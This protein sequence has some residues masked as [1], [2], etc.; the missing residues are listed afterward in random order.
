MNDKNNMLALSQEL[1]SPE[2]RICCL[3]CACPICMI[4][5][6]NL[7]AAIKNF[8]A[9]EDNLSLFHTKLQQKS[10]IP[11]EWWIRLWIMWITPCG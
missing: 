5:Q 9:K 1:F 7:Q 8:R 4:R 6:G 2:S 11:L 10:L 3:L